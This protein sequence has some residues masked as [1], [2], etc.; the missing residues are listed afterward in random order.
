MEE[1]KAQ[2]KKMQ[3]TK[4]DDRKKLADEDVLKK[5]KQLEEKNCELVKQISA[6]K[7]C[8]GQWV[9]G[10]RPFVGSNEEEALLNEIELTG[11][12]YDEMQEQN[13]RLLQQLSS[14]DEAN[15]KLMSEGINAN[16]KQTLLKE[17]YEELEKQIQ[18]QEHQ[19]E[20]IITLKRK[21]EE[22]E[23]N[24]ILTITNLEKEVDLKQKAL[25]T[26]KRKA[27]ESAQS[28]QELKMHLEKYVTMLVETQQ[29]MDQKATRFMQESNKTKNL[30]EELNVYKRKIDRM[31]NM[32]MEM[33]G[34]TIDEVILQ[35]N[36]EYKEAL[37]CDSCKVK[38]KDAVLTKC[39][40]VFCYECLRNRYDS[41]Q[42]K[43]PKCNCAFGAND[44]HRLYLT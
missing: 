17:Q 18:I 31:K 4:R 25:E 11:Q 29:M 44:F 23:K 5:M 16:H 12:A 15:F 26:Y 38:Q 24:L 41:R 14:K 22:K 28:A 32:E 40:H 13:D 43:C 9:S 10:Y 21:L 8:D 3:D 27:T 39:F 19:I 6:Q 20:T 33:S 42:R 30:Q 1:L 36:R 7:A 35:E 34:A 2:M 37:T